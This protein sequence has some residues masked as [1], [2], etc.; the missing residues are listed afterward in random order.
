MADTP[1][2]FRLN[3]E[4]GNLAKAAK[5]YE[6]LFATSFQVHPYRWTPIGN[7]PHLDAATA[8]ELRAFFAKYYIPNNA[9]M[10][11][12]GDIKHD[13]V[14][15]KVRQYFGDIPRRPDPPVLSARLVHG[16]IMSNCRA[17]R[18]TS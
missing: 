5:M 4:V 15:A 17:R 11:V 7:M 12:V 6:T 18:R 16:S 10:I 3:V 1:Q 9:T 8:D 13:A 2:M 14:I